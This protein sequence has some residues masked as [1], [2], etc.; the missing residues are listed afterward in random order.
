MQPRDYSIQ[1]EYQRKAARLA[2][3]QRIE[4]LTFGGLWFMSG[5]VIGMIG[6][7]LMLVN[8]GL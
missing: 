6:M 1:T 3:L 4:R 7:G 5:L 8:W 2:R